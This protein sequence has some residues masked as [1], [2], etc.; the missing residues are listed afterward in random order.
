M[1][2]VRQTKLRRWTIAALVEF[3][4]WQRFSTFAAGQIFEFTLDSPD[5]ASSHFS[6]TKH[7]EV[8]LH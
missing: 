6:H 4:A 5:I 2:A 1:S 8:F 3:L 7:P